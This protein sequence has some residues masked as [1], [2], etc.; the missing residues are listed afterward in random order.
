MHFF[1]DEC[2]Q[3]FLLTHIESVFFVKKV[4]F[5]E[6]GAFVGTRTKRLPGQNITTDKISTRQKHQP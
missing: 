2:W 3:L 1:N 6:K 5:Y 4:L